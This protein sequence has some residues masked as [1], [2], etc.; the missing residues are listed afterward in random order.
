MNIIIRFLRHV[1]QA[2]VDHG[3]WTSNAMGSDYS[4]AEMDNIEIIL[5]PY[6]TAMFASNST[7]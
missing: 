2:L 5:S 6:E 3:A 7:A 1:D 4:H